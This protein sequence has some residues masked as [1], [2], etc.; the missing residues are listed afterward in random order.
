MSQLTVSILAAGLGKR[1]QSPLPKVLHE[2]SGV[3]MIVRVVKEVVKLNPNKI[4]IIVGKF[5]DFIDETVKKYLNCD[6]IEYAIQS[7]P[8][9]TG[10]AIKYTLDYLPENGFNLIVNG[11]NPMLK[12]ETLQ[13]AIDHFINQ[14]FNLQITAIDTKNPFGSGRIFIQ[15]GI[16]QKIIEEKDC[17]EEERYITIV[18]TGIYLAMNH[19]LKK[20]I[21]LI[22]N[23]N[24]QQEY[25]LTDI[26][27]LYKKDGHMGLYILDSSQ[28]L[29][30]I[31]INTKM[32]LEE[33]NKKIEI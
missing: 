8:L 20:Y 24:A 1:M 26:V 11:D 23:D 5:K 21:P 29:E 13:S 6:L 30:V 25:Y 32:Q 10:D 7:E 33:L 14:K 9:G 31:N 12:A 27:E 18:N 2:V 3:P 22:Q 19:V 15:G 16:F 28:E 17:N 4:I